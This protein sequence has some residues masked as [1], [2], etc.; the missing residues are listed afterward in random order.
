MLRNAFL[1]CFS[2][3]FKSKELWTFVETLGIWNSTFYSSFSSFIIFTFFLFLPNYCL[4][5]TSI[6]IFQGEIFINKKHLFS[7][8]FFHKKISNNLCFIFSFFHLYLV[9]L[10][11]VFF[12]L[13][14]WNFIGISEVVS[15]IQTKK[16]L[17]CSIT[18]NYTF[19]IF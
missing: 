11:F 4:M 5:L 15:H 13:F 9:F 8:A 19:T 17:H 14:S 18:N 16:M 1:F 10:R 12:F 3:L 7:L 6:K 2:F